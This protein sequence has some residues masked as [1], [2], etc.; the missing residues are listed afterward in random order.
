M[1]PIGWAQ[2]KNQSH[3]REVGG[4]S[5]PAHLLRLAPDTPTTLSSQLWRASLFFCGPGRHRSRLRAASIHGLL[6]S[7][8]P[9]SSRSIL[10]PVTRP[11]TGSPPGPFSAGDTHEPGHAR[12]PLL[13]RRCSGVAGEES[14]L[15][16]PPLLL[17]FSYPQSC[18][19][20]TAAAAALGSGVNSLQLGWICWPTAMA[21]ATAVLRRKRAAVVVLGD[22]GRSPRMQYHSLSLANQVCGSRTKLPSL[23]F[24]SF[25]LEDWT[26]VLCSQLTACTANINLVTMEGSELTS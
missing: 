20:P 19:G 12:R 18:S 2:P 6:T 4:H 16:P 7:H 21:S 1:D 24:L 14:K 8:K 10:G 9:S 3:D 11:T 5:P 22:I 23:V 15:P 25:S 26:G 13:V 17:V